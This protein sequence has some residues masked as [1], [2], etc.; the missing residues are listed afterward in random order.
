MR[1]LDGDQGKLKSRSGVVAKRDIVQFVPFSQYAASPPS[2][3]AEVLAE[4][5]AQVHAFCSANG[6][7]PPPT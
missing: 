1:Q 7:I 2:L 6:F 3:A 5:P 4:I